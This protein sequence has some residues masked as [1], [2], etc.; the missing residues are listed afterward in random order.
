MLENE[1]AGQAWAWAMDAYDDAAYTDDW[2]SPE[3][4]DFAIGPALVG[5]QSSLRWLAAAGDFA[6]G[7]PK[8]LGFTVYVQNATTAVVVGCLG[9]TEI[10]VNRL[11][12]R[13]VPGD[14][15]EDAIPDV[16]NAQMVKTSSGWKLYD[17][18]DE[19]AQCPS[20]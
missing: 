8:I 20:A 4:K 2:Q 12:G 6:V 1:A 3:L 7:T 13:P 11:T 19:E 14:L 10:D 17:Q 18:S 5:G 16:F 9:G 15:G